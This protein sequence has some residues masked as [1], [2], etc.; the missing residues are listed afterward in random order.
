ME[1]IR[2]QTKR[3]AVGLRRPAT[4]GLVFWLILGWAG[5]G[6][7]QTNE[8]PPADSEVTSTD[9]DSASDPIASGPP[10]NYFSLDRFDAYLEL[11][12]SFDY[13]HV[14]SQRRGLFQLNTTQK[15]R[16]LVL[17]EKMGFEFEGAILDPKLATIA[18]NFEV[19]LAQSRSKENSL[20]GDLTDNNTG[21]LVGYDLRANLFQGRTI[22]GSVYGF[23][24]DDRI[25]R[26]FQPTLREDR[27]GYGTS[28]YFAHDTFPMELTIETTE[29]DRTGNRRSLNDEHF[30]E[31]N[32]H[33]GAQWLISDRQKATLSFEHTNNKQEFQGIRVPFET[34]RDL[35]TID[36][37]L[38]FGDDE[39]HL[40]RTLIHWQEESGSFARDFF[41]IGPQLTLR[42]NKNLHTFYKYQFNRERFSG[43]DIETQRADFQIVHQL[44]SNLTTTLDVF[45]LHEDIEDDLNTT[46]TG[47][48]IDWQ[49]N[50]R[51]RWGH[52]HAN[53]ALAYDTEHANGN[54]GVRI[55]LDESGTFRDPLP[56]IIRNRNVMPGSIVVTDPTG[57]ILF[58]EGLDYLVIAN[59]NAYEL[60]RLATG[61]IPNGATVFIDYRY[62]LPTTGQIDTMRV[63]MSLEQRFTNGITP[64]YRL[65]Y[66]NQED[67]FSTGFFGYADRT[68]HHRL[69]V[70]YEQKRYT[71]GAEFEIFDD[72]IEPYYA[73]HV[74]GLYHIVQ[75]ADHSVDASARFSRFFFEGGFDSRNVNLL[76]AELDHRWRMGDDLSTFERLTFR[77]EDDSVDG[78]TR[79][80]DAS[81]GMEYT[82]GDF[83]AE[84]SVEYDRLDLPYSTENDVSV[85]F[86]LRRDIPNVLEN[87]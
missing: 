38:R 33:Y 1:V 52:F 50:R 14:Q 10:R 77:W 32:L 15:N 46:Q 76:D 56:I 21:Y 66:R 58:F 22:S 73:F 8:A 12:S 29:T 60:V 25:P 26:R 78:M 62:R 40:L 39:Q 49:Y 5:R 35:L 67:D 87:L 79:G 34:E 19:G 64:Y 84:V 86:R 63:D 18:G 37:E 13:V 17:E 41:E 81:A 82:V 31:S 24:K 4:I 85:W 47:A 70:K 80:W 71:A 65:S 9:S 69:G 28:W 7:A 23:Q 57:F 2:R 43:V 42:H 20:F 54:D 45:A 68:N 36:H 51:N 53:L 44:Y 55:V 74:D 48:S 16:D 59:R 11:E 27:S 72:S 30:T 83:S 6:E 75:T 61:R 3:R